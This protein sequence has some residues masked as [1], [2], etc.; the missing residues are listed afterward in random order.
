[1]LLLAGVG[2]GDDDA[3][4]NPRCTVII[5]SFSAVSFLVVSVF[6]KP[7]AVSTDTSN[8]LFITNSVRS[9]DDGEMHFFTCCISAD[10]VF[11]AATISLWY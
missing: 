10:K 11:T 8:E 2:H 6:S 5:S 7:R 9:D 1:M 3:G 4:G